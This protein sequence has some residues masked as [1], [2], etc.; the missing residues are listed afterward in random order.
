MC[1][2]YTLKT[3]PDQWGQLLLPL[4]N[5]SEIQSD[6]KPRFNIA[7]TQNIL[8]ITL[9]EQTGGYLAQYFR[10]GL[11]PSWAGDLTI[12]NRMINARSE[13]LHEKRSFIAALAKRR[14][15]IVADGYYEWQKLSGGKKQPHWISPAQGGVVT[16]A[17]LWEENFKA[18][19]KVVKS[20]TI[21]T[22]EACAKLASIHDRM[23]ATL[24]AENAL[25]WLDMNRDSTRAQELLAPMEDS[26]YTTKP[27]S[28]HVNN[29]RHEDPECL[30]SPP[31]E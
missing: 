17:G 27:V 30:D 7:P 14:C 25:E 10:W 19:D 21:I 2:R 8:A 9:A 20:C 4:I 23:P 16:F 11:V 22:T 26:F 31:G 24:T 3:A 6:W 29:A 18:S 12:G 15:L 1:G 5:A 13:T 28:T